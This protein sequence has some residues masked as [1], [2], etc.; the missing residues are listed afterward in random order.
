[1]KLVVPAEMSSDLGYYSTHFIDC[2]VWELH[3]RQ[4]CSQHGIP[5]QQVE[6]GVVG[7]FPTFIVRS[8]R[9]NSVVVK[10]FG[11]L[12]EGVSA[13]KAEYCL[14][15]FLREH[16]LP[17]RSP[18]I[19]AAGQLDDPWN[20][21]VFEGIDGISVGQARGRLTQQAWF[22]LA[23]Q[24]GVFMRLLHD[25]TA[26]IRGDL[27]TLQPGVGWKSYLT[28]LQSQADH[29]LANHTQ[30]NELP[31]HLLRQ[32]PGYLLPVEELVDHS[33]PPHLIHADLTAD[34]LLGK[35]R[36]PGGS[37][38]QAASVNW[39]TLAVIDWGDVRVGNI[40]YDLVALHMDLFRQDTHLLKKCLDAYGLPDFFCKH[41]AHKA[42]CMVLL[43]Q[44]PMPA[45][46]YADQTDAQTLE[47]LA[48]RL[49][50]AWE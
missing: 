32:I 21:L 20:Y 26:G 19:L 23:V 14:G 28:F 39:K 48:E 13:F 10:F 36:S 46:F 6:A 15:H 24:M 1:M 34:H 33:S 45:Q 8:G 35:V 37:V 50:G 30:W 41:F 47:E 2:E 3:V 16:S 9:D 31:N 29:C 27:A 7:T 12:F 18:I 17:I 22:E 42:M 25:T 5:C 43:H 40:L 49:F 4:I 44:F 38:Y 11:P